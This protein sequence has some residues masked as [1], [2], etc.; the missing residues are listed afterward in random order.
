M[1]AS[2]IQALVVK[3]FNT[4]GAYTRDRVSGLMTFIQDPNNA[5]AVAAAVGK[6]GNGYTVTSGG[7]T[8]DLSNRTFYYFAYYYSLYPPPSSNT[9]NCAQ[10]NTTITALQ[11][12]I[13]NSDKLFVAD[14]NSLNHSA[15][16]AALADLTSLYNSMYANLSCDSYLSNQAQQQTSAQQQQALSQAESSQLSA[17]QQTQGGVGSLLGTSA[18]TTSGASGTNYTVWIV[19]GVAALIGLMIIAKVLKK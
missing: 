4:E 5:N 1:A 18:P 16:T 12:E 7:G 15:R 19:G 9:S 6:Y 10:I 14:N 11:N 13:A 17:F 3:Y 8:T 2:D